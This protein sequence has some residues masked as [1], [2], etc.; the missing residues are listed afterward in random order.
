MT[1]KEFYIIG[2]QVKY[3]IKTLGY[4]FVVVWV[5]MFLLGHVSITA[6]VGGDYISVQVEKNK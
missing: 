2:N 6:N 3:I 5:V 4:C 1:V